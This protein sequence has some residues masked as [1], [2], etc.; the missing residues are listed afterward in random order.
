MNNGFSG[1]CLRRRLPDYFSPYFSMSRPVFIAE[2]AMPHTAGKVLHPICHEE[3]A[4]QRMKK[5]MQ[6]GDV[7]SLLER[8]YTCQRHFDADTVNRLFRTDVS[9]LLDAQLGSQREDLER[10]AEKLR[11][12]PFDGLQRLWFYRSYILVMEF[13]SAGLR[14]AIDIHAGGDIWLVPRDRH[15]RQFFARSRPGHADK[16]P[17]ADRQRITLLAVTQDNIASGNPLAALPQDEISTSSTQSTLLQDHTITGNT[18]P[19]SLQDNIA[20]GS[21][22]FDVVQRVVGIVNHEIA[23]LSERQ[24]QG[25]L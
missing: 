24:Q 1:A 8:L 14:F 4:W 6:S 3:R 12:E 22:L 5:R 2:A 15:S 11:S 10:L 13:A 20:S 19:T 18:Q 9:Q 16:Y 25:V 23:R 21:T 17:L 7:D